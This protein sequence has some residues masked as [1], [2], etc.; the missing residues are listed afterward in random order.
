MAVSWGDQALPRSPQSLIVWCFQHR[1]G[2]AVTQLAASPRGRTPRCS[3]TQIGH[4]AKGANSCGR[5]QSFPRL[6]TKTPPRRMV[7]NDL[8]IVSTPNTPPNAL[9]GWVAHLPRVQAWHSGMCMQFST[10]WREVEVPRMSDPGPGFVVEA[11]VWMPVPHRHAPWMP[12]FDPSYTAQMQACLRQGSYSVLFHESTSGAP[13]FA[14][15]PPV[16]IRSPGMQASNKR[17]AGVFGPGLTVSGRSGR[18]AREGRLLELQI[19]AGFRLLINGKP[20]NRS[21]KGAR[22]QG[23]VHGCGRQTLHFA[24]PLRPPALLLIRHGAQVKVV[25][26]RAKWAEGS[27]RA[28]ESHVFERSVAQA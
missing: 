25:T 23:Q 1:S 9:T 15:D 16:A 6:R 10:P 24:A 22:R 3:S 2:A 18:S 19:P 8:G 11:I 27:S 28:G 21:S 14:I 4:S 20:S 12:G 7:V 5:L 13:A 26:A 17:Q